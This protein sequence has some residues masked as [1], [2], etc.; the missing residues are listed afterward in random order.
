MS[1]EDIETMRRDG[2]NPDRASIANP[3]QKSWKARNF[4][5]RWSF[6]RNHQL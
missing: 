4:E 5:F 6:S 1:S 3:N 2:F